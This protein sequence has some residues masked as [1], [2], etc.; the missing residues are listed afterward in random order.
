MLPMNMVE[1]WL[2]LL[3]GVTFQY[4]ALKHQGFVDTKD[5]ADVSGLG[6]YPWV[7]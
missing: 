7:C 2:M 5:Q 4:V 3:Q 6:F 1:S